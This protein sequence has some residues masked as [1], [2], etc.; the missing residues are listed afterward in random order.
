MIKTRGLAE[1][2]LRGQW[3]VDFEVHLRIDWEPSYWYPS[4]FSLGPVLFPRTVFL[5]LM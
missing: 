2:A 3:L 5:T 1:S 4:L